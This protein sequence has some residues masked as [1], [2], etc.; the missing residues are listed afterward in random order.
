MV[1]QW[2]TPTS[3]TATT[4]AHQRAPDT[5]AATTG[6]DLANVN[7]LARGHLLVIT[8]ASAGVLQIRFASE[9]AGTAV[10]VKAGSALIASRVN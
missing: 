6:I 4:F 2:L 3:L 10:T 1:A 5:G 8:G 9:S 7:S